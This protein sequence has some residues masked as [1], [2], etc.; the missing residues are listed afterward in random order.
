MEI[1]FYILMVLIAGT[2]SGITGFGGAAILLPMLIGIVGPRDA[3][4][5]LTIAQILGN[6]GRVWFNFSDCD[7]K[8]ISWFSIGA[9]PVA[10]FGAVL[11]TKAPLG[12]LTPGLGIALI[13]L[14][15]LRRTR[16][17]DKYRPNR[18][19]WIGIGAGLGLISSLVG[20]AG[21]LASPFFLQYG[22]VKRAYIGTEAATALISHL[23][24]LVVYV[25]MSLVFPKLI[26]VGTIIGIGLIIGAYFGKAI[27]DRLPKE[28]FIIAVEVMLC[29]AGLRLL[30][31]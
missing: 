7:R 16:W 30:L 2:V 17:A 12:I 1:A 3:V 15:A 13:G 10:I 29:I 5:V 24:K 23:T 20:T 18:T 6:A 28:K 4:V 31:L 9:I 19:G 27:V 26:L 8:V 11:F 22:L 25:V 21:P 14:V